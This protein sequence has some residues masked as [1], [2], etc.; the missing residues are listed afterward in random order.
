MGF[1]YN[2]GIHAA[3]FGLKCASLFNEKI[4][5][6]VIGRQNTFKIL[7]DNLNPN[8][9]TLWFHCASLGEYEQGLPVFKVLR[10]HYKN[11]KIVLSFFSPSG[12][13]I[14]KN[15][16]IADVVVYLPLDTKANAKRFLDIINP[17]LTVF[18]KYDIWPNFLEELKR[19]QLRAIL[20]SA[21]FRENQSFFKFYGNQL[22]KALFAFEHIFT[23]NE[24]SK[25]LLE[26]INYK[27]VTVTGDT[28]FDRVSSQ[29]EVDN[30]LDFVETFKQDKLCMVAGST[31]PEDDTLLINFINSEA[32][33]D[34]KF[35]IAPHNMKSNQIKNIQ[36]KLTTESV[37]FSEKDS[38]KLKDAQVFIIDI[39]GILSKIYNYADMA[40]VGGAMGT[41]GLHNTLEP[42][43]FGVP[44]IIG[45]HHEKFPEA[46][47]M[48]DNAGMFSIANQEE[49]DAILKELIQNTEKRIL[50]GNN[51]LQYIKKN[52]GA[53]AKIVRYLGF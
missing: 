46:K 17:E 39:I 11:H 14:R 49:F 3:H 40:Y 27:N 45:N 50:S 34:V 10:S 7:R 37:L 33:K 16:P 5:N 8:D 26:S 15:T 1:I 19:R 31:W 41:T 22:R 20:I 28:R 21:V 29:L 30:T 2:I 51:N 53:V 38:T 23:Q 42:A 52:K 18:V 25:N 44:I 13:D 32:S 9:Q 6:G 24:R 4:K 48:I 36:E 47:E 35:I 12:Y 43:V